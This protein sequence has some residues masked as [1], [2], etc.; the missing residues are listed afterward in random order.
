M[1]PLISFLK[2]I[3]FLI[4]LGFILSIEL[5]LQSGLYRHFLKPNTYAENVNR[6]ADTVKE[7]P[8]SRK[9]NVLILGTSVAYQGINMPLLNELIKDSGLTAQS[10]ATEGAMLITQHALFRHLISDLPEAK[11][12]IHVNEATF[13]WTARYELD[14]SN[15]SMLAQFPASTADEL[16]S[17]YQYRMNRSDKMFFYIK[18][19]TYQQDL[20]DFVMSPLERIKRI[21]R[22]SRG[23][24]SSYAYENQYLFSM[25]SYNPQ[26]LNDCIEKGKK[27]IPYKNAEGTEVSDIH[28]QRAVVQTCELGLYDPYLH[29]GRKQWEDLYFSN[30]K[31][32][33]SEIKEKKLKIITVFPPYSQLLPDKFSAER[34]SIWHSHLQEIHKGT[35][36]LYIDLRNSL[37]RPDNLNFYY[38]TIHLNR[39]G[40]LLFTRI[41]AEKLKEMAPAILNQN[42]N[43][44]SAL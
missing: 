39:A 44:E 21:G 26:N 31:H 24:E 23:N 38:D 34:M 42:A 1:K 40:S 29:P 14:A 19:L 37:D 41:L 12:V 27:G 33:Y 22:K 32:F 5:F 3:R 8:V 13:P 25:A 43:T 28:H 7:S 2:D 6:I 30:L 4:P 9:A 10:G 11:A 35:D 17:L 36:Y 20:H 16:L 15:K 18:T